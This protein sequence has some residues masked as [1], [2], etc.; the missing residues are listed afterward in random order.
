[1]LISDFQ[2]RLRALDRNPNDSPTSP[3]QENSRR[4]IRRLTPPSP[5][6]TPTIPDRPP[7]ALPDRPPP[8]LPPELPTPTDTATIKPDIE[9]T[10]VQADVADP[11]EN[12]ATTSNEVVESTDIREGEDKKNKDEESDGPDFVLPGGLSLGFDVRAKPKRS[13]PPTA[14]STSS[15]VSKVESPVDSLSTRLERSISSVSQQRIKRKPVRSPSIQLNDSSFGRPLSEEAIFPDSSQVQETSA[16]PNSVEKSKDSEL[17][18]VEEKNEGTLD[19]PPTTGAQENPSER[20]DSIH[21]SL[22]EC[23]IEPVDD[24]P[25]EPAPTDREIVAS[26]SPIHEE[27]TPAETKIDGKP[28]PDEASNKAAKAEGPFHNETHLQV[29]HDSTHV[30][31]GSSAASI[32]HV[33]T[34]PISLD[35]SLR[36][37]SSALQQRLSLNKELPPVNENASSISTNETPNG[38]TLTPP[39]SQATTSS[40]TSPSKAARQRPPIPNT[41]SITFT[42]PVQQ[43]AQPR[44]SMSD[45]SND[46]LSHQTSKASLRHDTTSSYDSNSTISSNT[47]QDNMTT[48]TV[49][50]ATNVTAATSLSITPSMTTQDRER[51]EAQTKLQD[52]NR[53]LAQAKASGNNKQF[54][55]TLQDSIAVIRKEYLSKSGHNR[56]PSGRAASNMLRRL[57]SS[58]S[59]SNKQ[60][61]QK[62][63]AIFDAASNGHST[64]LAKL[65]DDKD[66]MGVNMHRRSDRR[67]PLMCAA[68]E[69]QLECMQVLKN[70]GADPFE[71]DSSSRT[72]LH[73]A[74]AH[75]R[76]PSV[77][78]LLNAFPPSTPNSAG[79][80]RRKS[81]APMTLLGDPSKLSGRS[82]IETS[83]KEGYRPLHVAAFRG[84]RDIAAILLDRKAN[85]HAK[86]NW[87]RTPLFDAVL[88]GHLP[89]ITLLLDRGAAYDQQDINLMT[90]LHWAAEKD[91]VDV[92]QLLFSRGAS[93]ARADSSGYLPI[94]RAAKHG[95]LAA[96]ETFITGREDFSLKT[97][98]GSSLLH[99]AVSAN[100]LSVAET[101][102]KNNVDVNPWASP[103]PIRTDEHGLP[104]TLPRDPHHKASKKAASSDT[105][106]LHHACF[107]GLFE[108]TALLIDAG[109][110]VNAPLEDGRSPLMLAVLSENVNV[111]TLLLARGAKAGAKTPHSCI[112]AAHLAAQRADL[113]MLQHL[114]ANGA[115]MSAQDSDLTNVLDW[116]FK[117]LDPTKRADCRKWLFTVQQKSIRQARED[118]QAAAAANGT[119]NVSTVG[120]I[121][122]QGAVPIRDAQGNVIQ[123]SPQ[124]FNDCVHCR[125]ATMPGGVMVP[126]LEPSPTPSQYHT[127]EVVQHH[128]HH[129]HIQAPAG[130]DDRYDAF[131]DASPP[132]YEPGPNAPKNLVRREGVSRTSAL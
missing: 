43:T 73:L 90:P 60:K 112:T 76:P 68:I 102:I 41:P 11:V 125:Q 101:L 103:R 50:T 122:G 84:H 66:K 124:H 12:E 61:D 69:G 13:A 25:L 32:E 116:T 33:E 72:V 53:Q 126:H 89:M 121:A 58:F 29:E 96:V 36:I 9:S 3:Q 51:E 92:I 78:W 42:E 8:D 118:T 2:S 59:L 63:E 5:E 97:Q 14:V 52:L 106:P 44:P 20:P 87:M 79:F 130:Y 94:H 27:A 85:I 65:L 17:D 107:A 132:P 98:N 70:R 109:A 108:M 93:R 104:H 54:E 71:V 48:F 49:P 28:E 105:T 26:P 56:S 88:T 57:P 100:A 82:L 16:I 81:F 34:I 115:S 110:W 30:A 128:V 7:P 129:H 39:T 83:D 119:N 10:Q 74:V 55:K 64:R 127:T 24:D 45:D 4:R 31:T 117:A 131:P 19:R 91:H 120:A 1:M 18:Q 21:D 99:V 6:P 77:Q 46:A 114:Y 67:T 37:L 62:K 47:Q 80:G 23:S 95:N 35:P 75:N 111:V 113:E 40:P 86:N 15:T 38:A 22:Y 123:P